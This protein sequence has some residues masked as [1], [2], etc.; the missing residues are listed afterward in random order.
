MDAALTEGE[1]RDLLE[2]L[3]RGL[4]RIAEGRV[5]GANAAFG[6]LAGLPPGELVGREIGELFTDA[7]DRPLAEL[8]PGDGFGLRDL[9]GRLRPISLARF[10]ADLWLVIDRERESRLEREV[11]RL[12]N[13]LRARPATGGDAP[14]GGEQI[15]MIEHEIRTA[16]TAVRGYLRWLGS[17]RDRLLEP[18]H[19]SYVREARR[20]IERVGP[21]LDN[22]LELARSGEPLPS[23]RKPVRLHDVIELAV[24]T[25]RPLL[26]DRGVKVECE[27][28]A[29]PD[30][31]LG[32]AERLEQVFVNLLANAAG[33]SPEGARVRIATDL[34]ELEGGP[35]LQVAISD[36]GPGISGADAER[37]FRPFVRGPRPPGAAS[38]GV[39]LGL[40]I[41]VRILSAH[42][43]R[44]EAVPDLGY[45]LFRVTLPSHRGD[46]R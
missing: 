2:A 6:R 43:G 22:L 37:V 9:A 26:A 12:A 24:R 29:A 46:V 4:L 19:W 40:A 39:G 5:A 10:A 41:C 35:V 45:G 38:S 36:E 23:G 30:A 20:A 8:E 1:S 34:A 13:E 18:E 15:G 42:G 21:L 17:E 44:I 27:L 33:F 11:W 14:L 28:G 7:G 32:D 31:V 25:A 3:D 16:V